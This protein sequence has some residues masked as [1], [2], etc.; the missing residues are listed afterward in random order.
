[1][2]SQG[3][4]GCLQTDVANHFGPKLLQALNTPPG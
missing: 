4:V 3:Q 2:L 1:M